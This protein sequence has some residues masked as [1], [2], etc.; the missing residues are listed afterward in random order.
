MSGNMTKITLAQK[1]LEDHTKKRVS[2]ITQIRGDR[3]WLV[4]RANTNNGRNHYIFVSPQT[5]SGFIR[6]TLSPD[7]TGT[8]FLYDD[9]K[10]KVVFDDGMYE[11]E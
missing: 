10:E 2:S 6:E 3:W 1:A 8:H 11:D 4:F 7:E 9:L 5:Q